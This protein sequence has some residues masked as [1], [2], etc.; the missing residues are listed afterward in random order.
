MSD[1]QTEISIVIPCHNEEGNI[2]L[3]YGRLKTVLDKYPSYEIIFVDDGS[4]DN[5]IPKIRTIA[6]KDS[7]VKYISFSKNF[8]HQNALKAG[9]DFSLGKCSIS[10]DADMQH[11]P[12]LI[13]QMIE[14]WKEGFE[15]VYTIRK[16]EE[17]I[18]F[19]KK[20]TSGLFYWLAGKLSKTEIHP[21]A[22]DFRLLDKKVVDELKGLKENYLFFRGLVN[23]MGFSQYPIEFKA[24]SRHS[25]KTKYSVKKM[26]KFALSGITSFSTTPLQF[27]TIIGFVIAI[28]AFVY[29]IYAICISVFTNTAV[30]G[31]TSLLVSVLFI[32]GLQLIMIGILGEYVGKLFMENKRR[33]NYII[34]EK[35]F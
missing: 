32:G 19:F 12:E 16:E 18:S 22:A 8:G 4:S 9:F 5:T 10:I 33:P 26:F 17:N 24:E 14:K 30:P 6:G 20:I 7:H 35:N 23:W 21:G 1:Y 34:R 11:P 29:G 15:V 27:S 28:F 31:W 13:P 3:L 25:G 2:D